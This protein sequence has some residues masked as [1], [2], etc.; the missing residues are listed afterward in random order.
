MFTKEITAELKKPLDAS[1]VK[2]RS[3]SGMTL[4][5]V[6]AWHCIDEAN[7]IFGFGGWHRETIKLDHVSESTNEG[8]HY[9]GYVCQ[10]RITVDGVVR[11]G[12]GFGSGIDRD[13]GRAH[14][15]AVKEAESDAMKRALMTFGYTFGLALYDKEQKHVETKPVPIDPTIDAGNFAV[16][17]MTKPEFKEFKEGLKGFGI[18]WV[19][20]ILSARA[21]GCTTREEVLLFVGTLKGPEEASK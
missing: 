9:I 6:E 14:E 3:Q 8:K 5:Y 20:A 19:S 18:D 4:S 2:S 13:L 12:T 16:S 1:K 10:V 21:E 17:I 15:S 7:R 11:E